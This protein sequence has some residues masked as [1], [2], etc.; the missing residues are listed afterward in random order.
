[1]TNAI[2]FFNDLNIGERNDILRF[3]RA[4]MRVREISIDKTYSRF[5]RAYYERL[6]GKLEAQVNPE[7]K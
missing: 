5:L 7:E 6:E 2:D 4:Y 1:M 3:A